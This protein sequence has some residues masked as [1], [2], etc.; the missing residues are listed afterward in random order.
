M[1]KTKSSIGCARAHLQANRHPIAAVEHKR[2]LA[3]RVEKRDV[4]DLDLPRSPA[5]F[6]RLEHVGGRVCGTRRVPA[7]RRAP[8]RHPRPASSTA[9]A[10]VSA[11]SCV[12]AFLDLGQVGADHALRVAVRERAALVQPERFVAEPLDQVERVRH[13]QDR[14]AAAAELGKL[15]E[16]LVGE[17]LVADCEHFV[18]QQHVGIDVDR[19]RKPEAHVHPRGVGLHR[20]VDE[21]LQLGEVDDLVEP[22]L[23]LASGEAEHDAVDED[24]LASRDLGVKAGA[25]LDERGDAALD[26]RPCRWSVA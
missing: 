2:W 13:E 14:L 23:D 26:A 20:R 1:P 8:P 22:L 10:V 6:R 24:V 25:Q 9:L 4:G 7:A 16:A 21:F 19:D 18:D 11:S 12:F 15:V 3:A 17:A 5:A